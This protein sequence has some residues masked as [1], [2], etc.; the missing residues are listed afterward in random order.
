VQIVYVLGTEEQ[1]VAE[2]TFQTCQGEMRWV[3]FGF[4]GDPAAH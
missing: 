1:S 4:G 2:P 3:S